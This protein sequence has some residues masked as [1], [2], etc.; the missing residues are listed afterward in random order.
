MAR[1][2]RLETLGLMKQIGIVPLFYHG[3][4]ETAR[5]VFLACGRGGA[6]VVE[7][8]NRGDN[9]LE[10][11]R[12]VTAYCAA[13]APEIV[14]GAGSIVDAPTAA[15]FIAAGAEFIVSPLLDEDIARLCNARKI[16][17]LPGCGSL[18]EIHRAELLGVE[19]VKLFPGAVYGPQFVQAVKAPCPWTDIMPTGGVAP[20]RES[21]SAW[22]ASGIACAGMG[23]QLIPREL[24]KA[25][26]YDGIAAGIKTVVAMVQ[27]IRKG[28]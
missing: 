25:H 2:S 12:L 9:A 11:F 26:D 5:E 18:T 23:S 8:T 16:P 28:A 24:V 21:L 22:F 10:V 13:Q 7:F 3:D 19:I 15:L 1:V 4:F 17:Y 14:P 20:T 27:A 6:R